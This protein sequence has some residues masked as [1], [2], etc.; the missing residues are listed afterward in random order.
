M[1]YGVLMQSRSWI[2]THYS[3][4][5]QFLHCFTQLLNAYACNSTKL[6][7]QTDLEGLMRCTVL[8]IGS[9]FRERSYIIWRLGMFIRNHVF[10]IDTENSWFLLIIESTSVRYWEKAHQYYHNLYHIYS[11]PINI[12]YRLTIN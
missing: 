8:I 4:T 1:H 7:M 2:F 9:A 5:K 11:Y 10:E 3:W 6:I 12:I